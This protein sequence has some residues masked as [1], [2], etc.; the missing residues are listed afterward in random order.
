MKKHQLKI[1][2]VHPDEIDVKPGGHRRIAEAHAA[3]TV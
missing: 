1:D 3:L 2:F